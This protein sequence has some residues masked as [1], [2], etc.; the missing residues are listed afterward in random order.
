MSKYL[1]YKGNLYRAVDAIGAFSAEAEKAA[2]SLRKEIEK[3]ETFIGVAKQLVSLWESAYAAGD[4][5]RANGIKANI[6]TNAKWSRDKLAGSD[7]PL[8]KV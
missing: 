4:F 6:K 7:L 2:D 1:K 8:G 3:A 5:K